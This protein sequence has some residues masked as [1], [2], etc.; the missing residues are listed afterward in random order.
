MQQQ[1]RDEAAETVK[2]QQQQRDEAAATP[3]LERSLKFLEFDATTIPVKES[4]N[5]IALL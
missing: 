1:Q 2:Q 5:H 4:E 3:R